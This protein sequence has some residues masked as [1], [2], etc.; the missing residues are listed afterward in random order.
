M[1]RITALILAGVC[2]LTLSA[3]EKPQPVAKPVLDTYPPTADTPLDPKIRAELDAVKAVPISQQT[4]AEARAGFEKR[5]ASTPKLADPVAKVD[6]RTIPSPGGKLPVRVYTPNGKG[7]FSVVVYY[8]GGGWVLGS[9]DTHDDLCRSL[10][11]RAG[12]L[13]VS[14]DYR[15][16]PEHK[17]PAAVE[18]S[19]AALKWCAENAGEIGG[20]GKRLATA[21]DSAGGNL[22]AATALYARDKGGPKLAAQVLIY[23]VLNHH[24]DTTSYYQF[25]TGYGLTRDAMLY[26]WKTYLPRPEEATNLYASPLQAKDL[27]GLPPALV[28]TAQYDVLRDEGEAYAVRLKSAGVP[29]RATR[30]LGMNHGFIRSGA[31]LEPA[32]HGLQEIADS[33]KKAFDPAGAK[34]SP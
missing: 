12:V 24:F 34:P 31:T 18:D 20:D 3:Q 1:R 6:N 27:K 33:L 9:L 28:L 14:V 32:K 13:V 11:S 7:P 8:H 19:H 21:G 10:C 5:V 30:Y 26:Y 23:P 29:V 25:A 15:L 4:P 16:A 17:F 2:A 22:A